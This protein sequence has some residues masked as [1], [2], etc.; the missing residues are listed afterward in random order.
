MS[1][2]NDENNNNNDDDDDDNSHDNINS[3]DASNNA[4]D[5]DENE[6]EDD[7]SNMGAE[8]EDD[9]DDEEIEE[10]D[11]DDG[12]DEGGGGGEDQS[13]KADE[14][15][16]NDSDDEEEDDDGEDDDDEEGEDDGNMEQDT[17]NGSDDGKEQDGDDDSD[18][19][20]QK[21]VKED[22]P[23]PTDHHK[24]SSHNKKRERYHVPKI[25]QDAVTVL[26]PLDVTADLKV[27]LQKTRAKRIQSIYN[28][29]PT[30]QKVA[31]KKNP[32][33]DIIDSDDPMMGEDEEE[34]DKEKKKAVVTSKKKK[35]E[36]IPQP[37]QFGSVLDY[38]EAK[39][40]KGVMIDDNDDDGQNLDDN[41]EGQGSVYSKDSF[42]DDTD[43]QR[44]V[45]E[46][47]MAS[48]TLTKVELEQ[49]DG[50]FFVNV[51]NLELENDDYGEN[52]DPLQDK[53]NTK[54]SKKK[55]RKSIASTATSGPPNNNSATPPA[56]KKKTTTTTTTTSTSK[57]EEPTSVK[58]KMSTSSVT[59]TKSKKSTGTV[60]NDNKD[61]SER[62]ELQKAV[63][64]TKARL[65][66]Q[67]KKGAAMVK[68]LTDEE[69]PK[70]K[71][72]LKVALTCPPNKKPGDD[73][74]FSNPHNPGQRL[75]VKVPKDCLPGSSFKVTVPVKAPPEEEG[76]DFNRFPR[77]FQ[78]F[79]DDYARAYDDWLEAKH[80]L[81]PEFN[82]WKER[83]HK[84]DKFAKEFPSNLVTPVDS[85]YLKSALR[86][87]RQNKAKR[88]KTKAA[89]AAKLKD[90][91]DVKEIKKSPGETKKKDNTE[92]ETPPPSSKT[93]TIHIPGLGKEFPAKVWTE[94]DF[95]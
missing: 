78:D 74:T 8:L 67:Y 58:S 28:R 62:S 37:E 83:Q 10:E 57:P 42:L 49:E 87:F 51:G 27:A 19:E 64:R 59:S 95:S 91:K 72:K 1:D 31:K 14:E 15:I 40:V 35:L 18:D 80:A 93:I 3:E 4:M 94:K 47:V 84:F 82:V 12:D 39:Y 61:P 76:K 52:Y 68:K 16:G 6:N 17:G 21:N 54:A 56:K 92:E 55:K 24:K 69:L 13:N 25:F 7:T 90:V 45:A 33:D 41:S 50:D 81:D 75:R 65:D 30:L 73:I 9:D 11:D 85:T 66:S 86:R 38:L 29:F 48:T 20:Q 36:H 2:N 70:R 32:K 26:I 22:I 46:Q 77:E 71:T 43:L 88:D 23:P 53:E 44:D 5:V 63:K 60:K 34:H 79:F 89:S